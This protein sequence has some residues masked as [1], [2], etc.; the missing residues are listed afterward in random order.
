M[1][2]PM[3]T[4]GEPKEEPSDC[5]ADEPEKEEEETTEEAGSMQGGGGEDFDEGKKAVNQLPK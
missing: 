2:Q 3:T 5:I 4:E 1:A